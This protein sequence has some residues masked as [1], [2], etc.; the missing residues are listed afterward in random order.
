MRIELKGLT[1]REAIEMQRE[2]A[3]HVRL[4]PLPAP[5]KGLL[6]GGADCSY[7]KRAAVGY[8]AIVVHRWPD[9]EIVAVGRGVGE[10]EFPYVP[11]LLSFREMPLLD[12]AWEELEVKPD[13]VVLDGQ[14]IAHPRRFGL[15]A[16]AGVIWDRPTM[17]VAKSLLVGEHRA[18]GEARGSRASLV[19][20]GERVGTAV[21][22][23]VGVKPV[24]VSPGFQSD[25]ESSV[26]WTLRLADRC[27]L[28]EVIRSA[29]AEVNRMRREIGPIG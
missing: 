21:R 27:R 6:I 9:L 13:L 7:E 11:G 25:F 23:R 24:Y 29:H 4:Q 19:D 26:R 5:R 22:T 28:P 15:A 16:H 2:L 20:R 1:P 10:V 8:A 18:L 14:G 12:L 17:G 3:G